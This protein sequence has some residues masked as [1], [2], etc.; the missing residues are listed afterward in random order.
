VLICEEFD[1][2]DPRYIAAA[3]RAGADHDEVTR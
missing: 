3:I 1:L 2:C